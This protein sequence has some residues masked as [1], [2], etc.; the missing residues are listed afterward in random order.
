MNEGRQW[1]DLFHV[2][3]QATGASQIALQR[4]AQALLPFRPALIQVCLTLEQ[5]A[6]VG[7]LPA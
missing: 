2:A 5:F 1:D 6:A 7:S 3:R 4:T